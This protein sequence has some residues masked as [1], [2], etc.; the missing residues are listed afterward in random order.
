MTKIQAIRWFTTFVLGERCGIMRKRLDGNWGMRWNNPHP[1]IQIPL[2]F[3]YE[4]TEADK[5]FREDFIKR[6][7]YADEFSD[8]TLSILHECGHWATRAVYDDVEFDKIDS[9]CKSQEEYQQNP[10]EIL[11]TQWAVCWLMTPVDREYAHKF[12][13]EF[14]GI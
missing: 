7:P 6:C 11:A 13:K 8:T 12:E 1:Y 10:W 14:F 5:L 9:K 4:L 2:D 3:D